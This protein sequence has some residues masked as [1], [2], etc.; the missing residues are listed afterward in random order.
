MVSLADTALP[1]EYLFLVQ[2]ARTEVGLIAQ[3]RGTSPFPEVQKGEFLELLNCDPRLWD[4]HYK[5]TRVLQEGD[6]ITIATLVMV[7]SPV[8]DNSD[9]RD[10]PDRGVEKVGV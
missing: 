6:K 9:R 5:S 4:V 10:L 2:C 3:F 7:D 1:I 8:L